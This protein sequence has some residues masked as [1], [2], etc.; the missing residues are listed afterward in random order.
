MPLKYVAEMFCDRIAA[1]KIYQGERYTDAS[2]YDYYERSRGHI[3]I[4]PETGELIGEMLRV[5]KEEGED[6]AFSYVRGLLREEKQKST[7]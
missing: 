5:L 4:H 2:A 3:L 6:A 7:K 1:C